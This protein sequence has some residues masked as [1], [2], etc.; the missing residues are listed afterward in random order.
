[1]L[2]RSPVSN[3]NQHVV[4][5]QDIQNYSWLR[6]MRYLL[7]GHQLIFDRRDHRACHA[8]RENRSLPSCGFDGERTQHFGMKSVERLA[9]S[10]SF[11]GGPFMLLNE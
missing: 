4:T 8:V 3:A 7:V 5:N 9:Q 2:K 10:R 6:R 11:F 1:M